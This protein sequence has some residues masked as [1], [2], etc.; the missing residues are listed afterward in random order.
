MSVS[1]IYTYKHFSLVHHS[2]SLSHSCSSFMRQLLILLKRYIMFKGHRVE[3]RRLCGGRLTTGGSPIAMITSQGGTGA[4]KLPSSSLPWFPLLV[5]VWASQQGEHGSCLLC[6]V[7]FPHSVAPSGLCRC[8]RETQQADMLGRQS[9][10]TI[11]CYSRGL[12][13]LFWHL[14]FVLCV[15]FRLSSQVLSLSCTSLKLSLIWW[16]WKRYLPS[17]RFSAEHFPVS[18]HLTQGEPHSVIGKGKPSPQAE[19]SRERT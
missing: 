14:F 12:Q 6:R 13:R 3:F 4:W 7:F 9:F 1:Y 15:D 18:S 5:T 16:L 8:L 10:T 11:S 17:A 2:Q 19:T